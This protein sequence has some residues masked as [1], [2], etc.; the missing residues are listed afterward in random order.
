MLKVG[1]TA[2]LIIPAVACKRNKIKIKIN[3]K[4]KIGDSYSLEV[5][6]TAHVH[7]VLLNLHRPSPKKGI[8]LTT[9]HIILGYSPEFQDFLNITPIAKFCI[10]YFTHTHRI[11]VIF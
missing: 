1:A 6:T 9:H 11:L 8:F 4:R 3:N 5:A 10:R 7:T 2:K